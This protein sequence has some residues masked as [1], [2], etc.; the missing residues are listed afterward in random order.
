MLGWLSWFSGLGRWI[1]R[2]G[3]LGLGMKGGGGSRGGKG[4]MLGIEEGIV[5]MR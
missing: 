3:V 4:G 5:M 1:V 2:V